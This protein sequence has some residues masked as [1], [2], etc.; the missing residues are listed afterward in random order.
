MTAWLSATHAP[1]ARAAVAPAAWL[2]DDAVA[3]LY[4]RV[5]LRHTRWTESQRDAGAGVYRFGDFGFGVVLGHAMLL[6]RGT[7]DAD[8]AGISEDELRSRTLATI[9]HYAATNRNAGGSGWGQRL[10]WDT[11]FQ[12]YFVLAAR[13]LWD[14]LDAPTRRN[15]ELIGTAQADYTVA[16]GTA[17]D[18]MSGSWT[19]NGLQGGYRGD[20]KL[21]EM[22]VYA[23]AIG[24][25]LAWSGDDPHAQEWLDTFSLWGRNQAGLPAADAAN[26]TMVGGA[27]VSD[28]RAHNVWDTFAVENHGSFGPHYQSELWRTG[29][30]NAAHFIAAGRELPE[31]ITHQPNSDP[32]W[33]VIL[34]V[35][36]DSGEPLMPMVDDREHLFGRDVIPLA[37]LAQVLGDPHAA[38][39]ES[40]LAHQ[41][42][43]YLDYPP[44]YRLAKFSGEP[45][46]EPE[47]RAEITMSLL[48]HEW[49][50]ANGGAVA[51]SGQAEMFAAAAGAVDLGD[52]IGMVS[53][54]TARAWAGALSKPGFTKLAWQP[55]H[56]DWFFNLGGASPMY[57]PS[58]SLR[59]NA[60]D[61]TVYSPA[62][63]GFHASATV[64]TL[65][66]GRV[67]MTTLPDGSIVISSSGVADR[68]GTYGLHNL[69]MPG[70]R[71][72]DGTRTFA[73]A[74]GPVEVESSDSG[75]PLPSGVVR[76]DVLDLH[77]VTARHVRMLGVRA[78]NKYGYSIWSLEVRDRRGGPDL[79]VGRPTTASSQ[80]GGKEARLA[81]DGDPSTRWAVSRGDRLRQD[82]WIAVDL[83]EP[84]SIATV[85]IDWEAANAT[86]YELQTSDDGTTWTT[87]VVYPAV[88]RTSG[89]LGID[90]RV[91]FLVRGSRNP[92]EISDAALCL[93]AGPASGSAGMVVEGLPDVRSDDLPA[94]A[95]AA[96]AL[97]PRVADGSLTASLAGGH[98]SLF[99]L[100]GAEVRTEVLLPHPGSGP[101]ACHEGR[102]TV[103][104]DG[105]VLEAALGA[106]SAVVLP[107]RLSVS[108][109]GARPPAGLVV[110]VVDA[111]TVRLGGV[112]ALVD[113][114]FATGRTQ[115]IGVV[116][117]R[118]TTVRDPGG[119]PFPLADLALDRQTFP[120]SP[121]PP[122]MTSPAAAVDGDAATAW[123]V[124]GDGRM[125]VDLGGAHDIGRVRV[126]WGSPSGTGT[127]AVSDDGLEFTEV[128][129]VTPSTTGAGLEVGRSA[130]YVAL[131]VT[132]PAS[133]GR[134]VAV[135]SLSVLPA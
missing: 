117:A 131:A 36:S 1:A 22:G 129:R 88:T 85:R 51:P 99:N 18:P 121:L 34:G 8:E 126:G 30:R 96:E 61:T 13:L 73:T 111:A 46:Y 59:A 133:S 24:P 104:A 48:F 33:R 102:Q 5:L 27:P 70:V 128:G 14:E 108:V 116:P 90:D 92:I 89:W 28:N 17:R 74:E 107:P 91:A 115:R 109:G 113:V 32:L 132:A 60:R 29:G 77:G 35:M 40:N 37:F 106:S 93:S 86:A 44:E 23:Q 55:D 75:G 6:T 101:V 54:Q 20:T 45:K 78:V 21:E 26:P 43:P 10:F 125:V 123:Q 42:L 130:R 67:G 3:S 52:G 53:H 110:E 97:A 2:T 122:T 76:R 47:T 135:T 31:V 16:L 71:G 105:T 57:L 12:T 62:R 127:V 84:T 120:T 39:A 69:T 4:H 72:L 49:R 103:T 118:T 119:T 64:L 65:D 124:E 15:V 94:T 95:A 11:T 98:L 83:G 56:D 112:Q 58:T 41:L 81:T 50:A 38:Q 7:Y 68:E 79:A 19:P 134:R 80:D 66:D 9:R 87:R 114:E 63:D 82:S 100:G 25:G